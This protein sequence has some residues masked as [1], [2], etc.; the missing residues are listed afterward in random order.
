[1]IDYLLKRPRA[2]LATFLTLSMFGFFVLG[3]IP[4]TLLPTIS[5]PEITIKIPFPNNSSQSIE[6]TVS[7]VLRDHL[8]TL[9][10]LKDMKSISESHAAV[11]KL[12][13]DFGTRMDLAFIEVNEKI[14]LAT[15][16][17]PANLDR[18]QVIRA[19]TSD[20]PIVRMEVVPKNVQ[21]FFNVSNLTDKVIR[22]RLE[23]IKGVSLVD[24]NGLERNRITVAPRIDILR[25][26]G[27]KS[28][29]IINTIQA[30]NSEL[31]NLTISDG[32]YEYLASIS[33]PLETVEQLNH[34]PI[35]LPNGMMTTISEI[36]EVESVPESRQGGHY[37]DGIR[38]LV[39]TVHKQDNAKMSDV[40]DEIK[41][42]TKALNSEYRNI[43]FMITRDQS[44]LVDQSVQNLIQDLIYGSGFCVLLLF[45]FIGNVSS[46][47]LMSISIPLS[48]LL[49][50]ILFYAFKISFNIISLSGLALGIGMLIDNSIVVLDNITRKIH[51]GLDVETSCVVGVMEV[52]APV[53]SNVLTTV[54]IYLPLIYLSGMAGALVYDQVLAL[55]IS[56]AVSLLV[57]FFLNPVLYKF[58]IG[59]KGSRLKEDT[60]FYRVI[61]DKHHR[62]VEHVFKNKRL[63]LLASVLLMPMGVLLLTKLPITSLPKI[64]ENETIL[65]IDWKK[66]ISASENER[67]ILEIGRILS[68]FA[69]EWEVDYGLNQ[70]VFQSEGSGA[71][72]ATIYYRC[73]TEESKRALDKYLTR[74][75]NIQ[76]SNVVTNLTAAPNAFTKLFYNNEP[77]LELRFY[78]ED[79]RSF[80]YLPQVFL[81]IKK[82]CHLKSIDTS[83]FQNESDIE[84]SID[85]RKLL[86]YNVSATELK[87][88]LQRIFGQSVISQLRRFGDFQTINLV[89]NQ[90]SL[91]DKLSLKIRSVNGTYFPIKYFVSVNMGTDKKIILA[92]NGGV[93]YPIT[94]MKDE[95]G[96]I[97][98]FMA[99]VRQLSSKYNYKVHFTGNYVSD[100][101][102]LNDMCMIFLISVVL[103][104]SI[105]VIQFE[106]LLHP[107]VVMAIIPF[108]IGGAALLLWLTG[109]S[110]NIM[111][112]IG[113][114]VVLGII[115][116]DPCL[117]VETIN[118]LRKEYAQNM[119]L[120]KTAIL[121]KSLHKAGEISLKP[122]LMVSLTTSL[123]MVP[124]LFMGG[125]GNELQRPM[126]IVI[127]GGL[128]T[129]T[130]F[131]L[132][133]IPLLYWLVTK[134]KN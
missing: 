50:F 116:D 133:F 33:N 11:L 103:I 12:T 17:L 29:D 79:K 31:G 39:L 91:D 26:M 18:P 46:P 23:Q 78:D 75:I 21:E 59:K 1:M 37:F 61:S 94:I 121:L 55:T 96:D 128:T 90:A 110:L 27:L 119:G 5:I 107:L 36:A 130:F 71:N 115:V 44:F 134:S 123:A 68:R 41:E 35:K 124:V 67:R 104:Y 40:V 2:V 70:F 106:N 88:E 127:I 105:L 22:K 114:V 93:Y 97:D 99:S 86:L 62:L 16:S 10:G 101:K 108:G 63:Y 118:R 45:I 120:S 89:D 3:N 81:D 126:A 49:T 122:L 74:W 111:T 125:I 129:G 69:K 19:N 85:N 82:T 60:E 9:N 58:L 51:E 25:S 53:I 43:H 28:D 65:R 98:V 13:F 57:A 52:V 113:F 131:T 42:T 66:A 20:V 15:N 73:K 72:K 34:L 109:G 64:T 32:Q 132:W 7:R 56:L 102:L 4:I 54:A 92:D 83:G 47:I 87:K 117:K 80:K 76:F 100:R 8:K 77:Y 6:H 48:L 38:S 14:D 95:V 30:A 24:I 84:L 112:G